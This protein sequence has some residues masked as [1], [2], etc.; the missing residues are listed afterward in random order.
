MPIVVGEMEVVE[1]LELCAEVGNHLGF[2]GDMDLLVSLLT[3]L[4]YELVFHLCFGL[5]GT[6][7]HRTRG[8]LCDDGEVGGLGYEIGHIFN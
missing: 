1:R 2:G 7:L 8:V 4:C 5:V 3:E 6:I